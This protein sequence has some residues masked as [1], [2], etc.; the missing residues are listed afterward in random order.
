MGKTS[1][2]YCGDNRLLIST[3]KGALIG[4]YFQTNLSQAIDSSMASLLD[5]LALKS[6]MQ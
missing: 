2:N 5:N 4:D 1:E 3:C 6:V